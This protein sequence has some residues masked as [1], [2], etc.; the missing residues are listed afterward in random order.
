MTNYLK[1]GDSDGALALFQ[2]YSGRITP[3]QRS[4]FTQLLQRYHVAL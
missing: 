2:R 1:G 4:R 3:S